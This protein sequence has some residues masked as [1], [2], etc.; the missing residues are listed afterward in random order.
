MSFNAPEWLLLAPMLAFLG[1]QWRSLGLERPLRLLCLVLAVVILAQPKLRKGGKGTDLWV[2]VD[3]SASVGEVLETRIAEVE[4]ILQRAKGD[5]DNLVFVDFAALPVMRGEAEG[6]AY[7]GSREATNLGLAARF[8]LARI[9]P[10]RSARLLLL[11]DGF[12]TVPLAGLGEL[13]SNNKIP[14]DYRFFTPEAESD[15]RIAAINS[16]INIQSGDSFIVEASITGSPDVETPY[17]VRRNGVECARGTVRIRRG[18]GKL[19]FSDKLEQGGSYRYE[20]EIFPKNDAFQGNN[21][22]STWVKVSGG[23]R[24]LLITGYDGDPIASVLGNSGFEIDKI[25]D[26]R[27]LDEGLLSGASSVIINNVPANLIPGKFLKAL[28]FYVESQGRGLIMLGGENSF[29]SGG[30]YRSVIDELLP[31]SMEL[32]DDNRKNAFALAIVLDRS[33]S[34]AEAANELGLTKMD[35]GNEGAARAV[36]LLSQGD[37]AAVLAVDTMVRRVVPLTAMEADREKI[38]KSI[39]SIRSS[40]SGLYIYASLEAAW[41]ELKKSKASAKHVILFADAAD[42]ERPGDYSHLL[43]E[44]I[45]D[46]VTVSVIGMGRETDKDAPLLKDIAMLGNGRAFFGDDPADL[47]GLFS[48]E[49]AAAAKSSFVFDPAAVAADPLWSQVSEKP[50][51]WLSEV[52]GYNLTNL[53]PEGFAALRAVDKFNSPLAAF[54]Q[55]GAGRTVALCFPLSGPAAASALKWPGYSELVRTIVRWASAEDVPPGLALKTKIS[56]TMLDV[57]LFYDESWTD[58]LLNPPPLVLME[59][60]AEGETRELVWEKM[61]IGNFHTSVYLKPNV[62]YRGAVRLPGG[63][64]LPFGPESIGTSP[65]WSFDPDSRTELKSASELS[66]GKE[67]LD[68]STAFAEPTGRGELDPRSKLLTALLV[69]FLAEAFW[70]AKDARQS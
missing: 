49:A 26:F 27:L 14:L 50:I 30:Y 59:D 1:W 8:C 44:M 56:G 42:C 54:R 58:R 47:P 41:Q 57:D 12:S 7:A 39:R 22:A 63:G 13:L 34:M 32:D 25:S 11:S 52:D 17:S 65:E 33:G 61:K 3:R 51:K 6:Q 4:T 62:P 69:A 55:K 67:R 9:P 18:A 28:R 10:A 53:R 2:L 46:G 35:L 24:I 48:Q 64:S 36:K 45:I 37:D 31:V 23:P 16:P 43:H 21:R 20:V 5:V 19:R 38:I 29:G 15:Y 40:G 68:L 60:S 66:G 70:S